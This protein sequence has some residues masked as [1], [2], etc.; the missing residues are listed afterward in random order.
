MKIVNFKDLKVWQKGM[1][2][3]D[4]TYNATSRFPKKDQ[5]G[6]GVHMEKSAVS[7]PSNIAEG[8]IRRQTKGYKTFCNYALGSCGEL[9]TQLIIAYRRKFISQD[10]FE[11][12]NKELEHERRMLIS[13]MKKLQ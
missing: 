12:F 3:V 5:Y 4:L 8:H 11:I 9:E 1:D 13:L 7:I 10:R 2:L 6:I